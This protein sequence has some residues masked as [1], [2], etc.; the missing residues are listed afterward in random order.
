MIGKRFAAG[1]CVVMRRR[2][3][4]HADPAPEEGMR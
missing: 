3:A 4:T 1:A 2:S